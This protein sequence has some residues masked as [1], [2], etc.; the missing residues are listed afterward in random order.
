MKNGIIVTIVLAVWSIL[1]LAAKLIKTIIWALTNI[2]I[3]FGLYYPLFYLAFGLV[4]L[5][6]TDFT[7]GYMGT[8]QILYFVGLGLCGV[9]SVIVTWKTIVVRPI[10]WVIEPF[11]NYF[12]EIKEEKRRRRALQNGEGE[13]VEGDPDRRMIDRPAEQDQRYYGEGGRYPYDPRYDA[14]GGYAPYDPR[15][16]FSR[17][18]YRERVPLEQNAAE[19]QAPASYYP[20]REEYSRDGYLP[21]YAPRDDYAH[22]YAPRDA[23]APTQPPRDEYPSSSYRGAYPVR[24]REERPMIYYSRRRPG[25]LVKEYSD[26]FELYEETANGRQYVG[27]EYKDD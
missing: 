14:H 15:R 21:N 24:E 3:F 16:T 18:G 7:L 4:L 2:V 19:G 5:A 23:Y 6:T 17:E 25:V 11:V 8:N 26:R 27:T 10:S 1:K 12:A 22:T 9:A 20:P 13:F